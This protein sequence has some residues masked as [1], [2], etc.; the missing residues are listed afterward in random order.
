LSLL[1]THIAFTV[2]V[3]ASSLLPPSPL[4][5]LI[6]RTA[7]AEKRQDIVLEELSLKVIASESRAKGLS[8]SMHML[9]MA[10][11]LSVVSNSNLGSEFDLLQ[12][13]C[14]A[15]GA[16]CTPKQID[17]PAELYEAAVALSS[18]SSP[19]SDCDALYEYGIMLQG[20]VIEKIIDDR[21]LES[22]ELQ[23]LVLQAD[24]DS[25][26]RAVLTAARSST[27]LA[28]LWAWRRLL[29]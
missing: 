24:A 4:L 2:C 28:L 14:E 27:T 19:F 25:C 22:S 6:S 10:L 1:S 12:T 20:S 23:A 26:C 15:L 11:S 9:D 18:S 29:V 7:L 16:C 17:V 21:L 3:F 5:H 13:H 8:D